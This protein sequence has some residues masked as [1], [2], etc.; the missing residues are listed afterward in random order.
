V[1]ARLVHMLQEVVGMQLFCMRLA[2]LHERG[3]LDD[4]VASLAKLNNT[5]KARQICLEA[6]DLLGA[7]GILLDNHVMRHLA[8]VEA[9][10]T[11]EGTEMI[12]T[13]RVGRDITGVGAFA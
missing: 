7:N 6:R 5:S 11:Y 12:Q 8:D 9:I 13:L 2:Q 3:A 10:R 4:T 1:Q